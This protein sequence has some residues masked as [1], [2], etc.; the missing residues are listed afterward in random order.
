MN[1][2]TNEITPLLLM[3]AFAVVGFFWGVLQGH[4]VGRTKYQEV[5]EDLDDL[6][7]GKWEKK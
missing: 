6:I 1:F 5:V 3:A 2:C 7:R 4:K